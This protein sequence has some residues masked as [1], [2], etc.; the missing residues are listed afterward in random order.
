MYEE[1]I[2]TEDYG[3]ITSSTARQIIK[4]VYLQN[5]SADVGFRKKNMAALLY[6]YFRDMS[7][8]LNTLNRI[9][10]SGGHICIVWRYKNYNG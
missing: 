3:S 9:V 7:D 10:K 8:V 4:K 6:M 1:K 5:G 2:N